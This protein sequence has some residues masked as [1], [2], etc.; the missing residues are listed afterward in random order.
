MS[1]TVADFGKYEAFVWQDERLT[2]HG[3]PP[4]DSN[5]TLQ[6]RL[7]RLQLDLGFKGTQLGGGADGLQGPKTLA[8]LYS[9]P[10]PP[11][12]SGIDLTSWKLTLPVGE[13]EHP[14]EVYPIGSFQESPWFVR[15]AD[16]SLRFRAACDG[17]TTSGSDYPRSE[18][19]EMDGD[20]KAAWSNRDGT[21][22]LTARLAITHTL[23][24][25][26]H[27]VAAQ[28][29][30]AKTKVIMVRLEGPKLFVE[31]PHSDDLPL[32]DNYRLGTPFD[33]TIVANPQGIKVVYNGTRSVSLSHTGSDWYF[34]SGCYTQSNVS[35][36]DAPSAYGEVVIYSLEVSH[37]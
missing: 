34:K 35:K 29:H 36:G 13:P 7:Q 19:R 1:Y 16:G 26:Q 20:S 11:P 10:V 5:D 3:Y 8:F 6:N 14:D 4:L 21:H 28:I 32:D 22:T 25:K 30:D 31:S 9:D 2:A 33:L 24:K 17:V 18:L 15:N 37:R 12:P 23:V 27:V